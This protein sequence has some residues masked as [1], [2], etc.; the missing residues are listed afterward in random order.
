MI[1]ALGWKQIAL[2]DFRSDR[3]SATHMI[4]FGSFGQ[5]GQ[6]GR[7]DPHRDHLFGSVSRRL[8]TTLAEPD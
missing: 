1:S 4:S 7:V 6:Q 2:A 8:S 3:F 5:G